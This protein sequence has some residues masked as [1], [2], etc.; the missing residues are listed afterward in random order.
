MGS[1]SRKRKSGDLPGGGT[2]KSSNASHSTSHS[3]RSAAHISALHKTAGLPPRPRVASDGSTIGSTVSGGTRGGR[4]SR[5]VKK[6]KKKKKKAHS[7]PADA[8]THIS[9]PPNPPSGLPGIW[10]DTVGSPSAGYEPPPAPPKAGQTS[11]EAMPTPP[12]FSAGKSRTSASTSAIPWLVDDEAGGSSTPVRKGKRREALLQRGFPREAPPHLGEK[13]DKGKGN[14]VEVESTAMEVDLEMEGDDVVTFTSD[15][16]MVISDS[17]EEEEGG[18]EEGPKENEDEVDG[19][20][21]EEGEEEGEQEE[22]D[23]GGE[24]LE[25][26]KIQKQMREREAQTLAKWEAEEAERTMLKEQND[27]AEEDEEGEGR[28]PVVHNF[29]D[30]TIEEIFDLQMEKDKLKGNDG[31]DGQEEVK[32]KFGLKGI[33]SFHRTQVPAKLWAEDVAARRRARMLCE[34]DMTLH[35]RAMNLDLVKLRWRQE[36]VDFGYNLGESPA[37]QAGEPAEAPEGEGSADEREAVE[38]AGALDIDPEAAEGGDEDVAPSG[39][40]GPRGASQARSLRA[41]SATRSPRP[42][43]AA[44]RSERAQSVPSSVVAPNTEHRD[45]IVVRDSSPIPEISLLHEPPRVITHADAINVR[46][47]QSPAD[48]ARTGFVNGRPPPTGL[49]T[50]VY[51]YLEKLPD[52]PADG[53]NHDNFM[54][55]R[56]G[57]W[58]RASRLDAY[59]IPT[60][61]VEIHHNPY[62]TFTYMRMI[63]SPQDEQDPQKWPQELFEG[64]EF[65]QMPQAWRGK[66]WNQPRSAAAQ[67]WLDDEIWRVSRPDRMGRPT[68]WVKWD[69]SMWRVIFSWRQK[70]LQE[71]EEYKML[72]YGPPRGITGPS[73]LPT[74]PER[75]KNK[76]LKWYRPGDS[77]IPPPTPP[78]KRARLDHQRSTQQ[79]WKRPREP[80]DS[81]GAPGPSRL[82][83]PMTT[84]RGVA[85]KDRTEAGEAADDGDIEW[86]ERAPKMQK[87]AEIVVPKEMQGPGATIDLFTPSPPS[88][89]LPRA[90]TPGPV[91]VAEEGA[92]PSGAAEVEESIEEPSEEEVP[93]AVMEGAQDAVVEEAQEA[94]V[95]EVQEAVAEEVEEAVKEEVQEAVEEEVQED[96]VEDAPELQEAAQEATFGTPQPATP[97]PLTPPLPEL[98][99]SVKGAAPGP[100]H[101]PPPHR[102]PTPEPDVAV[103][104]PEA[105]GPSQLAPDLSA[106]SPPAQEAVQP[107]PIVRES[108]ASPSPE[109]EPSAPAV[110]QAAAPEQ[111]SASASQAPSPEAE[112]KRSVSSSPATAAPVPPSRLDELRADVRSKIMQVKRWTR[113]L[114]EFPDMAGD[115]KEQIKRSQ[116]EVFEAYGKIEEEKARVGVEM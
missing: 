18:A 20:E 99:L 23:E 2:S 41:M 114:E 75:A 94:V 45:V 14:A 81:P 101:F 76:S 89:P 63:V 55:W 77:Y 91:D 85:Y 61:T 72:S 65:V 22:K 32:A 70:R 73:S 59:G 71:I 8:P 74:L 87:R 68:R 47:I 112:V 103:P 7:T 48:A 38:G 10:V 113:I 56:S 109:R 57:M 30:M 79:G 24:T 62:P 49:I 3:K 92:G 34:R 102:T 60:R 9:A 110:L 35:L 80:A 98:P 39:S 13:G 88:S 26:D 15:M 28:K 6:E 46:I 4:R 29:A 16:D 78:N 108:S 105:V 93:A 106:P 1:K 5:G 82:R 27:S 11:R 21:G 104:E 83:G 12:S 25:A 40:V 95:E 42:P 84:S 58:A 19:E 100:N 43:S 86:L 67:D 53:A 44:A 97:P 52:E 111:E 116:E 37:S 54:K 36:G 33:L 17:E 31:G 50:K 115:V 96:I 66:Q 90:M 69:W 51:H 107:L 64:R